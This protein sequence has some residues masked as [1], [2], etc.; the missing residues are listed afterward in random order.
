MKHY[1]EN[2]GFEYISSNNKDEFNIAYQKFLRPETN[3]KSIVFELFTNGDDE[4][5]ALRLSRNL[6]VDN[7]LIVKRKLRNIVDK[8]LLRD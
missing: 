2:L 3:G 5:E 1:A 6:I 4:N 7:K 8:V